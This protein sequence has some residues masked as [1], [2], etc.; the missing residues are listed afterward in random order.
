MTFYFSVSAGLPYGWE[1]A[2]TADG[3]KYYIK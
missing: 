1:E 2:Y 3:V